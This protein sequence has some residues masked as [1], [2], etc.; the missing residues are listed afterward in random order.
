M[1]Y[2]IKP[3][4]FQIQVFDYIEKATCTSQ[5]LLDIILHLLR[6]P[7]ADLHC[8]DLEHSIAYAIILYKTWRR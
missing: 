1:Y 5:M 2:S 4:L 8:I 3:G 7:W 6:E